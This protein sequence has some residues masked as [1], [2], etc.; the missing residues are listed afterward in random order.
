MLRSNRKTRGCLVPAA[1][2]F[3]RWL[4]ASARRGVGSAAL[5]CYL[6]LAFSAAAEPEAVERTVVTQDGAMYRGE[7]KEYVVGDHITLKLDTGESHRI[8]WGDA[9]QISPPRSK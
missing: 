7:V 8:A 9:V 2:S 6:A 3:P 1:Q 5:C 4:P